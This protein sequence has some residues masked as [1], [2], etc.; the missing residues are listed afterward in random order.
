MANEPLITIVGNATDDAQL[1]FT[2]SGAAVANF[3]VAVTP[4]VKRGDEWADGDTTFFR[5]AVWREMAE[6]VAETVT[7]G[8]RLIV[9]GRF[10]TRQYEKDGQPRLSVEIDVDEVGPSLRYATA[11]IQKASR[12]GGSSGGGQAGGF[13]GGMDDPWSTSAPAPA[14]SGGSTFDETP[15]F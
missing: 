10:K 11:K 12:S 7:K 13:G 6:Q 5:C 8:M 14:R 15:P 4:R 3:T 2:P 9:H 1:R